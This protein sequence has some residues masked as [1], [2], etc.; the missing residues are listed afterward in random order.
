MW[1]KTSHMGEEGTRRSRRTWAHL[2]QKHQNHN[3]WITIHIK[4]LEPTPKTSLHPKTKQQPRHD[5]RLPQL[6]I[7]SNPV[8]TRSMTHKLQNVSQKCSHRCKSSECRDSIPSLEDGNRGRSPPENLALK[9]SGLWLREFHRTWG[10][11]NS[12]LGMCTQALMHIRTQE[13]KNQWPHKNLGQPHLLVLSI[14]YGGGVSC[15]SLLG[16]TLK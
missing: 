8:P 16:Q 6:L 3:S 15:G 12:T 7:K 10:N 14:Y 11:R 4:M 13:E 1:S 9:L 2:L 5:S